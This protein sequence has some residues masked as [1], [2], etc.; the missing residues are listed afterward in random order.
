MG[1]VWSAPRGLHTGERAETAERG[2]AECAQ[3][4]A[5]IPTPG[6]LVMPCSRHL[7]GNIIFN[8]YNNPEREVAAAPS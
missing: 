7:P 2:G 6:V 1:V 4:A 3:G 8:P 5:G